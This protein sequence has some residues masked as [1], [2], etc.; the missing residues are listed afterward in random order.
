L[1]TRFLNSTASILS[2]Q[3]FAELIASN[4]TMKS[5]FQIV[6]IPSH[7]GVAA[8]ALL[9]GLASKWRKFCLLPLINFR[10]YYENWNSTSS[11]DG[12]ESPY[13]NVSRMPLG[14]RQKICVLKIK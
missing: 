7:F 2:S 14:R 10:G 4:V 13:G 9:V 1:H 12:G 8:S 3:F 5:S 6:D 11:N